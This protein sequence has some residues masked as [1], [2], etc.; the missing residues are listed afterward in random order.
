MIARRKN[1]DINDYVIR[2]RAWGRIY[3]RK[4]KTSIT[5]INHNHIRDRNK[6]Q[7]LGRSIYLGWNP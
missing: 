7:F 6:I 5:R 2:H 4:R 1:E 3:D